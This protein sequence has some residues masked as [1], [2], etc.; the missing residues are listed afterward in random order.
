MLNTEANFSRDL[1]EDFAICHLLNNF[2]P[3]SKCLFASLVWQLKLEKYFYEAIRFT[4]SW[5]MMQFLHEAI[6]SLRFSRPFDAIQQAKEMIH[7]IYH[8]VCRK[9]YKVASAGQQVELKII[10][11]KLQDY[12]M[13]LL[14]NYNT[15]NFDDAIAKSKNKLHEYL[16]HSLNYQLSLILD[17]FAM[18]RHKPKFQI[19]EEL[20]VYKLLVEK[21][22]EMDN[23]SATRYSP[24]VHDAL[25]KINTALLNTLQNSVMN[26]TL[27]DFMF[28]VEIDIDDPTTD[29]EDLKKD[30]LQK[31]IG[32]FSYALIKTINEHECFQHDV[33]KQ[34]ETISIKPKTLKEI[35][36][37]AT[38]GTVL[39]KIETSCNKKVWLD[40]LLNRGETL[41]CNTE[42]LQTVIDNVALL[43][44]K[45]L[46]RILREHQNYDDMD[47]E[48]ELQVREILRRG[49]ERLN[50]IELRD[51]T[52]E[53]I[54]IFGVDYKLDE[55]EAAFTCS[56]T[57]YLNKLTES[58]LDEA[59]MWTLISLNPARFYARLLQDI[60]THDRAQIDIVLKI[61]SE[62][63]SIADD[64][65]KPIVLDNLESA[66]ESKKSLS[67]VFLAGLFKQNLI[68]RKEFVRDLLME[69]LV[70]SMA[71]E[72]LNVISMLLNTLK[73]ISGKLK[74]E[75]LL[76][77]LMILLAQILDKYRWDLMSFA[78]L[79]EAIVESS[80]EIIHDL[81]RTILVHGAK[82]DK[83]WIVAK[84]ENCKTM[85]K[86][87]FQK[88]QLEK[89]ESIVSFDKFLQPEGFAGVS[90]N[91]VTSF[92]CETM[93]RCTTKEFKWL[94][95]NEHLQPF[96]TDALHVVTVIV[97]KAGQQLAS[98]CLHK[99]VSDYVKVL[100]VNFKFL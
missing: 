90:K 89:G 39:E 97:A 57:N 91:K 68:D 81:M 34:L 86:F 60:P 4:P 26:I 61:L 95:A 58:E 78:Q 27:D 28:W 65:I 33:A 46:M 11:N 80:V 52:E 24:A 93:V 48:D 30:N 71:N 25:A 32:E 47:R 6:D 5:F 38:V 54:R 62:T 16:G 51:F 100:K 53:L 79:R 18:F 99:C 55:D 72:K 31:S 45:D 23:H 7:A 3:L 44:F 43:K 10:L 96:I 8:N 63:N 14:R 50:N 83:D 59:Q 2:P 17:C 67:H 37:E 19:G 40:E 92:L 9:D 22:P 77:P 35:A 12:I 87:Y 29:D 56:V 21:E 20:Q 73:Q 74:L 49:G 84:T 70:K 88:L 75:D 13:S 98:N 1:S 82:K 42:C 36:K 69:N 94:M 41:Y 66:A 15:P 64:F 76:P 85:T